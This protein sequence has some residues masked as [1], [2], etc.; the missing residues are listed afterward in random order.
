MFLGIELGSTR[1]KAVLIDNNHA[2]VASG[3]HSWENALVDGLWTYSLDDVWNGL[4]SA[5]KD[6]A[7]HAKLEDV[8][9]VGISAMMH[10]YLVFDSNNN[11]LVQFRTWRNTNTEQAAQ[12]L[13]RAFDFNIPLRWNVA[14]LYQAILDKESHVKDIAF[15][16]TLAGYVH[17]QLTGEKVI[18]VG[19]ASGMFPCVDCDYDVNLLEKFDKLTASHHFNKAFRDIVPI[20]KSAGDAAGVLTAEGA[21]LLDPT[22]ALKPGIVFCPPEGD[23]GTGMVATNSVRV[24]TG[25]I[26]AGTSVFAMIVLEKSLSKV[27]SEIDMVTTPS[28]KPVAMVHCNNCCSD[29]DAWV[30]LFGEALSVFGAKPDINTL[31]EKLYQMAAEGDADCGGVLSYNF[32]SGEPMV[33]LEAGRPLLVRKPDGNF[34]LAN[35]MRSLIFS[36]IGSLKLGMDILESENVQ[37]DK[38]LG[39]GGFFKTKGI[40]QSIVAA[41]LRAPVT[42][43]ES[44]SEGGAWGIAILAAYLARKAVNET[45]EDY[46]ENKVF[47]KNQGATIAPNEKDINGFAEYMKKYVNGLAIEK[48]AVDKY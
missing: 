9:A 42:V 27:Y 29:I 44:A 39:H 2:L 35:T 7:Q 18:G 16:T 31:Y 23:A 47:S 11:Q 21:K 1:I 40:G 30:K 36:A 37:V 4:Q 12:L 17:W 10:G 34:N 25:N 26:S 48:A 15:L 13:T 24:R 5:V 6:L 33:G 8:E 32:F 38:L 19:D 22:G 20:V 14:H 28:G 3:S 45:L 41:A 43:M 46:L